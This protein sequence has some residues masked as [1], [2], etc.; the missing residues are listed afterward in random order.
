M[1]EHLK[2]IRETF[3]SQTYLSPKE[4]ARALY[5]PGKD[6]KKRVEDVRKQL[7]EGTLIPGIRKAPG[8]K[9]WLVKIVD[10]AR[11]LDNEVHWNPDKMV[12]PAP[13]APGKKSR[14]KNP[15]P[16]L[17]R[18]SVERS[19]EVWTEIFNELR[20]LIAKDLSASLSTSIVEVEG[21]RVD[22]AG[23]F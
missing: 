2:I 3:P 8:Q 6:S 23:V 11:A 17:M 14:F 22:Q 13:L 12:P 20:F 15:G 4:I 18:L 5:G 1:S 21:R 9:R 7:N 19:H 10:L 16:R